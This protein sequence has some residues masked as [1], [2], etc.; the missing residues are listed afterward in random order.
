MTLLVPMPFPMTAVIVITGLIVVG[1]LVM[2]A[3]DLLRRFLCRWF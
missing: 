2:V 1:S 3:R